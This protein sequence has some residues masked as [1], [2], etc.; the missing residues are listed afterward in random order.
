MS[1]EVEAAVAAAFRTEWTQVVAT[2]IRVTG[3][4]DLA[5]DCAQDAF[6]L[7]LQHWRRDGIPRRPGA[8]L[9]TTARN[10]A[11][12]RLRREAVGVAKL[13][14]LGALST[15]AQATDDLT[16]HDEVSDDDVGDDRLR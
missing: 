6:A 3:D 4:W 10:R 8:W 13:R 9:T 5:E 14:Q 15:A 7:A 11:T 16:G 1:D 2:L 12:D